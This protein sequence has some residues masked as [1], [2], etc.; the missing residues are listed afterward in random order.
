[1]RQKC[2]ECGDYTECDDDS[3]CFN[4]RQDQYDLEEWL[5]EDGYDEE[6]E[7]EED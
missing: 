6:S 1:M 7:D 2:E 4:C 5:P 3:V